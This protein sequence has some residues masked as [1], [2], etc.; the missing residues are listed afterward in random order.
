[1]CHMYFSMRAFLKKYGSLGLFSLV[2]L[3]LSGCGYTL[4]GRSSLPYHIKTIAIPTFDNFTLE[5]GIEDVLTQAMIDVFVRGGKVQLVVEDTADALLTGAIHTYNDNEA[6]DFNEQ[7]KPFK[8]RLAITVDIELRDL[9]TDN[10][11]WQAQQLQ[12]TADFLG[13]EDYDLSAETENKRKALEELATELAEKVFA[14][15]T[16]GF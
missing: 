16:E 10:I 4:V 2:L 9:T 1:M 11:L 7:N 15:S 12:G 3:T 6:V 5:Q 14:L 13:G 8:Y